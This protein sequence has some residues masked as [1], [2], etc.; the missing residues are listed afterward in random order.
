MAP[1]GNQAANGENK[2]QPVATGGPGLL[3]NVHCVASHIRQNF[4][5]LEDELLRS[6]KMACGK[7]NIGSSALGVT[8]R[9]PLF[10]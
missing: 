1:Q 5:R 6:E 7:D 9:V 4:A 8:A 2:L 10:L 3:D